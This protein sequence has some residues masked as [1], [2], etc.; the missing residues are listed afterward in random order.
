MRLSLPVAWA[1]VHSKVVVLLMF[2]FIVTRIVGV[3]NCSMFCCML[4]YVH[5]SYAIILM[6]KRGLVAMLSLSSWCLVMVVWLFLAVSWVCLRFVIVVFPDHTHLLF[7]YILHTKIG[8]IVRGHL[9]PLCVF[10]LTLRTNF[11]Y[12]NLHT[13]LL[14]VDI[15]L[16]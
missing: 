5:S 11:M 10:F 9:A 13:Y 7:L 12:F 16:G 6:E 2:L 3:R 1:A 15:L 4:L 8:Y 14:D